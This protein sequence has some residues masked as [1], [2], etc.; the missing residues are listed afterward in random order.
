MIKVGDT[1]YIV[2]SN[3]FVREVIVLRNTSGIYLIRFKD[4][5]GGIQVK[6]HRLFETKED[7]LSIRKEQSQKRPLR[8]PY[9]FE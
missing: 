5:G 4:T 9:D 6:K 8:S 3:R 7:E 2:E 1:S